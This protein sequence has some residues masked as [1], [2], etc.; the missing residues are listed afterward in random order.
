ML[1]RVK[2]ESQSVAVF[3][4]SLNTVTMATVET[5]DAETPTDT[6]LQELR[7]AGLS[8]TKILSQCYNGASVMC[9]K[10]GGVQK[11]LKDKVE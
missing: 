2:S 4:I 3:Q 7:T 9:G 10:H 11:L 5:R 1:W 6:I 8:T